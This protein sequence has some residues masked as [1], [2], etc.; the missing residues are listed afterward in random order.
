MEV[1]EMRRNMYLSKPFPKPNQLD[2]R[3]WVLLEWTAK[4]G[5]KVIYPAT[6]MLPS[7][8]LLYTQPEKHSGYWYMV[9]HG[10]SKFVMKVLK[11]DC[12]HTIVQENLTLDHARSFLRANRDK[13]MQYNSV[14]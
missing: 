6:P 11:Q 9:Q 14:G 7:D 1:S 10:K 5:S 4:N 2:N 8:K 12:D 3:V 13:Y